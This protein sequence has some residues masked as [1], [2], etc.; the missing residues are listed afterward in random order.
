MALACLFQFRTK[1]K[2]TARL[3]FWIKLIFPGKYLITIK[4]ISECCESCPNKIKHV[5]NGVFVL[6]YY[7]SKILIGN[8]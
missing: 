8:N 2:K 5:G 3:N 1:L 4:I 6:R 7:S